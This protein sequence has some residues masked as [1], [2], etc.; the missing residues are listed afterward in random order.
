[1]KHLEKITH[2]ELIDLG[3]NWLIK[4]YAAMA[5]YGHT[6]CAVVITEISCNTWC[7]EEPDIIGFTSSRSRSILIECKASR[8]DFRADKDKP[9]RQAPEFALGLQRWYLAPVGI[10]PVDELPDKWGLLEVT[11][12]RSVKVVK[13]AEKQKRN[14]DSELKILI[15]AMRRL[16]IQADGHVSIKKYEPLKGVPPSKNRATFFV[17]TEINE[18]REE[19]GNGN[20]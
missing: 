3:R 13:R 9:F 4:P 20:P 5:D 14:Y 19:G 18:S 1:M 2:A 11:E 12:E 17:N 16:N 6:G 10:I 15:S 8:S 7:G